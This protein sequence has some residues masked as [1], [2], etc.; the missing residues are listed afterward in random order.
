MAVMLTTIDNP[1]S[2][3]DDFTAWYNYDVASGYHTV[4]YLGRLLEGS[5]QLSEADQ[6][7]AT[8]KIIDEIIYENVLGIYKK[9]TQES[10]K[11]VT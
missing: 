4:E 10:S 9:V 2:P 1:H 5:D 7:I 6:E 3:F 11:S 8:E